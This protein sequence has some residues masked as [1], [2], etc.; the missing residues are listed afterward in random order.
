L[1]SS[2]G[3]SACTGGL[4]ARWRSVPGRRTTSTASCWRSRR[5]VRT[6]AFW[7]SRGRPRPGLLRRSTPSTPTRCSRSSTSA[8]I[9]AR[10]CRPPPTGRTRTSTRTSRSRPPAAARRS[11]GSPPRAWPT[12]SFRCLHASPASS[13]HCAPWICARSTL[14]PPNQRPPST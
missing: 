7:C 10:C 8:R 12:R 14:A 11:R 9:R 2:A 4:C 5:P 1:T 13:Q 6:C 3:G